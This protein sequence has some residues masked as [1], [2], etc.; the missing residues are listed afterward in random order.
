MRVIIHHL[1]G[2]FPATDLPDDFGFVVLVADVLCPGTKA[3]PVIAVFSLGKGFVSFLDSSPDGSGNFSAISETAV[4]LYEGPL[5]PG[6]TYAWGNCTYWVYALRLQAGEPIPTTWG[7]AAT[8]APR[9]A[10]DGYL[11]DHTPEVG[12]IMQTANSAHG[13][14]HVAYVT[15]VDTVTGDWTISEMNVKGLDIVDVRSFKT[16]DAK[17][18][19]FIH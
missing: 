11:V 6:D 1:G 7:D 5:V 12:A 15:A 10:K 14:G 3:K 16:S 4:G 9:A 13:L 19:N 2:H 17:G 8:W 18:Y